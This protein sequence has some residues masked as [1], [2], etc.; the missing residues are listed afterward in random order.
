MGL[1]DF[2]YYDLINRNALSYGSHTAWLDADD[3]RTFK[4]GRAHV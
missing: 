3:G 1:Y 2:T 4:I